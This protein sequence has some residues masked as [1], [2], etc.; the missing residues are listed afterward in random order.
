MSLSSW[1]S[2]WIC[3]IQSFYSFPIPAEQEKKVEQRIEIF[4]GNFF[5]F[6]WT[7]PRNFF[8]ILPMGQKGK[9]DF[10]GRKFNSKKKTIF[11]FLELHRKEIILG[12]SVQLEKRNLFSGTIYRMQI[13]HFKSDT[14]F[15]LEIV[16][17]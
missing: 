16:L 4:R 3:T 10:P 14:E 1:K 2:L 17:V 5:P 11:S 7:H 8:P 6:P 12:K 9:K 13:S 15:S